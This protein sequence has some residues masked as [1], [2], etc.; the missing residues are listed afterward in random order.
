MS[1]Y[2]QLFERRSRSRQN[3][4]RTFTRRTSPFPLLFF[5]LVVF[6]AVVRSEWVRI[7]GP[8]VYDNFLAVTWPYDGTVLAAGY[9]V[10][11]GNIIRSTDDGV[12]WTTVEPS[13]FSFGSLYGLYSKTISSTT[14]YLAVDDNGNIYGSTGDGTTWEELASVPTALFGVTIGS[15]GNAYVSGY[16]NKVYRSTESSAYATWTSV[17]P[18]ISGINYI[19]DVSTYDGTNVIIV[20]SRGKSKF[21]FL[22]SFS[23]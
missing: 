11:A 12:T 13:S 14:Y 4:N 7:P 23:F 5:C 22:F 15:N 19:N 2:S 6:A 10:A 20:G 1:D 17:S 18:T 9:Q 8:E 3:L 16:N 21:S